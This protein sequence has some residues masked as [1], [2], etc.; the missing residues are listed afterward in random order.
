MFQEQNWGAAETLEAIQEHSDSNS[1]HLCWG[2]FRDSPRPCAVWLIALFHLLSYHSELDNVLIS[3]LQNEQIEAQNCF[4][5]FPRS[6]P[7]SSAWDWN[8]GS[9]D[10]GAHLLLYNKIA[11]YQAGTK[12]RPGVRFRLLLCR[13]TY[14]LPFSSFSSS[15]SPLFS[16][17]PSILRD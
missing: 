4:T 3:I 13:A 16:P 9:V 1:R 11:R 15:F 10:P 5:V 2:F 12:E 17:S 8:T 7:W 6:R 14:P